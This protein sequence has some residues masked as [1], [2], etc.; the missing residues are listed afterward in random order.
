MRLRTKEGHSNPEPPP[1]VRM[2]ESGRVSCGFSDGNRCRLSRHVILGVEFVGS[3][4]T[5]DPMT[6]VV[7]RGSGAAWS[8]PD[9]EVMAA[10]PPSPVSW[11]PSTWSLG[12]LSAVLAQQ[13]SLTVQSLTNKT[14][15]TAPPTSG[16]A[17]S[18]VLAQENLRAPR[19]CTSSALI[20]S[21][22]LGRSGSIGSRTR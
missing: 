8:H 11:T 21:K 14:P 4:P 13:L 15:M 9:P 10:T 7:H 2:T 12:A 5:R 6:L 3:S 16:T 19:C 17:R 22:I 20:L 1:V 18:I